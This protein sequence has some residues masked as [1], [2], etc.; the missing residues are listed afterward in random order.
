MR[1]VTLVIVIVAVVASFVLGALTWPVVTQAWFGGGN[2]EAASVSA[3]HTALGALSNSHPAS[4][5]AV[6]T[7]NSLSS[8][9]RQDGSQRVTLS[10]VAAEGAWFTDRPARKSGT[11]SADKLIRAF[12]KKM[13]SDPPNVTIAMMSGGRAVTRIVTMSD[14]AWDGSTLTFTSTSLSNEPLG[15]VP[16]TATDVSI[17]LD[18]S[19]NTC[20]LSIN[21]RGTYEIVTP[22]TE[23]QY[24]DLLSVNGSE[25]GYMATWQGTWDEGCGGT[26]EVGVT[27]GLGQ[28]CG[29]V[30]LNASDPEFGDNG[31]NVWTSDDQ[32]QASL[33]EAASV[34]VGNEG[35]WTV[36][37]T[38]SC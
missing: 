20:Q 5:L 31:Y 14:V 30:S 11:D 32:V 2:H 12:V 17:T 6:V 19:L 37:A 27:N 13:P 34:L 23:T 9:A 35:V 38:A 4:Y 3:D 21:S 29:N 7:A 24:G 28:V 1:P 18:S 16:D 36:Y 26:L 33:D 15:Q 10:H 25:S 22:N 8:T